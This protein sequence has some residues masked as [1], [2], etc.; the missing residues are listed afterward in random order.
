MVKIYGIA[1]IM[2]NIW[3]AKKLLSGFTK[4]G[5]ENPIKKIRMG[6]TAYFRIERIAG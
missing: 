2:H 1:H 5:I 4:K 6:P 3:S